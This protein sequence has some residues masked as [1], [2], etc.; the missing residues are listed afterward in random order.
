MSKQIFKKKIKKIIAL[1]LDEGWWVKH[2]K[3]V[4]LR[5]CCVGWKI[6]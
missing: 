4:L 5:G 6:Y 1:K 2:I 3:V